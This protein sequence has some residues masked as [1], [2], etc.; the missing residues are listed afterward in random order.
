MNKAWKPGCAIL[1]SGIVYDMGTS[2]PTDVVDCDVFRKLFMPNVR[3]VPDVPERLTFFVR[4]SFAVREADT[5]IQTL[6]E[7]RQKL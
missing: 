4:Y 2:N 1:D 7:S 6:V 5:V 3:T